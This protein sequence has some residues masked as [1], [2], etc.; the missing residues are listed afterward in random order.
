[1]FSSKSISKK[2]GIP[3]RARLF[4]VVQKVR[5]I[6]SNRKFKV[7]GHKF[8]GKSYDSDELETHKNYELDYIVAPPCSVTID[9]TMESVKD[10]SHKSITRHPN[11]HTNL[12]IRWI[13]N[14]VRR[15]NPR[16]TLKELWYKL[17]RDKGYKR[18]IIALYRVTKRLNIKLNI[19]GHIEEK[20]NKKY[21][22]P[23][24]VQTDNGTEFTYN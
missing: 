14:Y 3:G 15:K 2:Y 6:N 22:I 24:E 17:K 8:G 23:K 10:K 18:T 13:R 5:E 11:S 9:G 12:E 21:D 20:N 1:M 7:L 16:I 19:K 4:E